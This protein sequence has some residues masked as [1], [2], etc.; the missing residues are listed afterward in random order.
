MVG[1][2]FVMLCVDEMCGG[3]FVLQLVVQWIIVNNDYLQ[4]GV[5]LVGGFESLQCEVDVF[6]LGQLF[7]IK[8]Y[9][10]IIVQNVLG[11]L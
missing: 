5:V 1:Q 11:K 7:D 10:L 6:F 9:L 8:Y 3:K 2:G 4:V